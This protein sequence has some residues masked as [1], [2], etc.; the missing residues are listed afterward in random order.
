MLPA[1]GCTRD[2]FLPP[3]QSRPLGYGC[4]PIWNTTMTKTPNPNDSVTILNLKPNNMGTI[5]FD[6][7]FKG[8]RKAQDF[9]I[10]PKPADEAH[11]YLKIQSD[12][13]IGRIDLKTGLVMLCKPQAS[14]AYSQH[15]QS[16]Q[17]AGVLTGEQ[18]LLLKTA[19]AST[20]SARAGTN[21]MIHTDNSG[22]ISA[23][24]H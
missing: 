17:P 4:L 1:T 5:D 16:I 12:T 7:Q 15:M 21:G 2:T 13:R 11:E 20:A 24:G 3:G 19:V 23:L 18:L 8:M 9:I 6:G 10:Y 14:G 22:A